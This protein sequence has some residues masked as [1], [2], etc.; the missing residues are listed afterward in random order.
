MTLR[1]GL[2]GGIGSGKSTVAKLFCDKHVPVI[3]ADI[4]ARKLVEP[5]QASLKEIS[6]QLGKEFIRDDG[7]L[8]RTRLRNY[9][10]GNENARIKLEAILHPR[11]AEAIAEEVSSVK[12]PYCVIVIP[13]MFEAAQEYLADRVLVVDAPEK[14]QISRVVARDGTRDEDVRQIM[15]TQLDRESRLKRA[16][17]VIINDADK[18][19]LQI[20]VARLHERYLQ[21]S[22]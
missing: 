6:D 16:D 21:M 5:G 19:A 10:F 22:R 17:D 14:N 2:T 9:I 7:G 1:V 13:L 4:I 11:V 15:A 3:D 20:Q 8:D 12:S 18:S